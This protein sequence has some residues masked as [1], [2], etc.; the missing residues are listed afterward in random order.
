MLHTHIES[1]TQ[2]ALDSDALPRK[3]KNPNETAFQPYASESL[4]TDL[5]TNGISPGLVPPPKTSLY[6]NKREI[7]SE[8]HYAYPDDYNPYAASAPPQIQEPYWDDQKESHSPAASATI[9]KPGDTS[10]A[11][12]LWGIGAC[13]KG[14]PM[15]MTA[16]GGFKDMTGHVKPVAAAS[17]DASNAPERLVALK[18]KINELQKKRTSYHARQ[19]VNGAPMTASAFFTSGTSLFVQ[20]PGAIHQHRRLQQILRSIRECIVQ[21]NA[22]RGNFDYLPGWMNAEG[23]VQ[24]IEKVFSNALNRVELDGML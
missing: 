2:A 6:L 10:H 11:F 22:L 4:E 7:S 9:D 21:I 8:E 19:G 12:G 15:S 17:V 23:E 13:V 1:S 20:V 16:A 18:E 5:C 3:P 14:P 24:I